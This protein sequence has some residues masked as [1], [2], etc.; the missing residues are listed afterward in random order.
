MSPL[1]WIGASSAVTECLATGVRLA[2]ADVDYLGPNRL[3]AAFP[4]GN[5]FPPV[6]MLTEGHKTLDSASSA[7]AAALRCFFL[8]VAAFTAP[9]CLRVLVVFL[10]RS[11]NPS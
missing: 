5:G 9:L 1:V 10:F 6:H 8:S 4:K 11:A 7:S 3:D 2:T